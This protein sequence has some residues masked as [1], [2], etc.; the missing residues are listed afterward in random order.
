MAN[1]SL[2][3]VA[4]LAFV[5]LTSLWFVGHAITQSHG[6]GGIPPRLDGGGEM[7]QPNT[8]PNQPPAP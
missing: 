4:V 7:T 2:R 1:K 6:A 3:K 8:P 5:A